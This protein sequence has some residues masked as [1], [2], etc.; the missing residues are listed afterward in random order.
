MATEA[1][2]K[3]AFFDAQPPEER[4]LKEKKF[5]PALKKAAGKRERESK[6]ARQVERQIRSTVIPKNDEEKGEEAAD[7]A[8]AEV[9]VA[10][11][12]QV[13]DPKPDELV[14]IVN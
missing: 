12:P 9:E 13:Q 1:D 3:A 8:P 6:S 4:K 14:D 11:E 7:D 10:A 2:V 5:G